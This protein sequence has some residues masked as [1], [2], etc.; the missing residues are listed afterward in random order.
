[1]NLYDK[2][3][4][5]SGQCSGTVIG[6]RAVLTAAHCVAGASAAVVFTGSFPQISST[7]VAA[8][9][10]YSESTDVTRYDVGVVTTADDL[11]R[12]PMPLLTSRAGRVGE[13]AV[14][15]G[16]GN[17][18]GQ[19]SAKLRA[20]NTVI[21]VAS[22]PFVLQTAFSASSAFVCQGDS[23]GP[24]LLNEAGTWAV[25]GVISANT[26][27][28]CNTGSNYFAAV[29]QPDILAFILSHVPDAVQR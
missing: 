20:G 11:G 29:R 9:P 21:T 3:G 19:N 1:M 24:L 28:A 4:T 25:G 13:P 18:A 14:V 7:S 12:P 17:D 15:A 22:D 23:G 26:N 27:T 2:L 5:L 16:W 6:P 10:N 8:H